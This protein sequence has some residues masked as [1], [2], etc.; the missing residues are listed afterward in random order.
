MP[1]MWDAVNISTA[2]HP[3]GKTDALL[4]SAPPPPAMEAT[5][6]Y[7]PEIS[8]AP[9]TTTAEL[10]MLGLSQ[11]TLVVSIGAALVGIARERFL[12]RSTCRR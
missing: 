9:D 11:M 3:A 8:K 6:T 7:T 2:P 1:E 10:V 12:H 5:A 4:S